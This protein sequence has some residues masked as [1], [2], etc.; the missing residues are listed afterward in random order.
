MCLQGHQSSR[1]HSH[2]QPLDVAGV[3]AEAGN[4]EEGGTSSTS[5]DRGSFPTEGTFE[6]GLTW[7]REEFTTQ[8]VTAE[9]E[10]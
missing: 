1:R 8:R 6:Q 3:P 2:R 7:K 10:G 5:G 9:E 4:P